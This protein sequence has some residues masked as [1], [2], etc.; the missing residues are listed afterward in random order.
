MLSTPAAIRAF[1]Q[2]K[3][4]GA[5]IVFSA[6]LIG[7]VGA[8][9][10]S[11]DYIRA[12]VARVKL[13]GSLDTALTAGATAQLT[14]G[15]AGSTINLVFSSNWANYESRTPSLTFTINPTGSISGEAA[16]D[17]PT[18]LTAAIGFRNIPISVKSSVAFGAGSAEIALVLDTTGSMTGSKLDGA[19][20]A[21]KQLVD[22][23]YSTPGASSRVKVGLVPF[24]NY[25]N[26]G[27]SNRNQPWM[28][29]PPDGSTTTNQC[30]WDYP[31]I[32]SSNCRTVTATCY[33]DGSPYSCSWTECDNVYGAAQWVCQDITTTQVWNGCAGSRAYPADMSD[34]VTSANPVPG[35]MNVWCSSELKRLTHNKNAVKSE[36]D[37]M[38]ASGETYIQ[39]GVVWGWRLLSSRAPFADGGA[40]S[41]KKVMVVMTDGANTKSPSYPSHEGTNATE[42]NNLLVETCTNA[43]AAGIE[44]YAIAF[45]VTE[46]TIT[47]LL[48]NCASGPPYFYTASTVT[49]LASAF[50]S[51]GRS[52]TQVRVMQ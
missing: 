38:T 20:A 34:L 30:W 27:V 41:V 25:V 44:I 16:L 28:S 42:A 15:D 50:A 8:V 51:I 9:G 26:V 7:V 36:I 10:V 40:D 22:E 47:T 49:E 48:G 37:A 14:G 39:A 19:K 23:V 6:A 46:P 13:Q 32:S 1:W 24:A 31:L 35:I 21:A 29:V 18:M 45:D 4:G 12:S 11:V 33:N 3:S 17:V 2:S 5:A 43:K 52:L